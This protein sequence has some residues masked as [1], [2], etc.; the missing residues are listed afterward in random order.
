MY[1]NPMGNLC[2]NCL[3]VFSWILVI[4]FMPISLAFCIKVVKEYERAVMFRLGKLMHGGAR[5][6]GLFFILP[7][8]DS[9]RKVQATYHYIFTNYIIILFIMLYNFNKISSRVLFN[10]FIF[11]N[12]D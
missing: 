12:N 11:Q 9:Y 1:D 2:S 8:V 3:I 10:S 5:G 7:C 6:P 4:M